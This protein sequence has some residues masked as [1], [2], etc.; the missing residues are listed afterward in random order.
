MSECVKCGPC[1]GTIAGL[2]FLGGFNV[3]FFGVLYC[4]VTVGGFESFLTI[5]GCI[6]LG[7]KY[8]QKAR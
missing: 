1:G 5:E 7:P 8:F 3:Y 6:T 2:T 4:K